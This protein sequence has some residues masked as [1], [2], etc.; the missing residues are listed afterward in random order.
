[1]KFDLMKHELKKNLILDA[2]F[3]CIYEQGINGISMRSIAQEAKVNQALIHYYFVNKDDLLLELLQALLK[4]FV[5]DLKRSYRPSDPPEKKIENIMQ[6]S[7]DYAAEQREM[8]TVFMDLWSL[9]L[10]NPPMQKAFSDL[11]TEVSAAVESVLKEGIE[12]GVFND[13]K[14]DILSFQVSAINQGLS[15]IGLMVGKSFDAH[16]HFKAYRETFL[17][18][19]IRDRSGQAVKAFGSR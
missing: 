18:Q 17:N 10:R 3:K 13:V 4:R 2:T 6:V 12:K 14:V 15:L 5:Y 7:E 19:V 9:A 1:M 16:E 11:F 8:F